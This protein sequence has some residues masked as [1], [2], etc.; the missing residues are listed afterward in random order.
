[1]QN[2]EVWL[3]NERSL[4]SLYVGTKVDES[5]DSLPSYTD[6]SKECDLLIE[7]VEWHNL[8]YEWQFT[9]WHIGFVMTRT[10]HICIL[11]YISYLGKF[12]YE[13]LFCRE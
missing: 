6:L 9:F 8:D 13:I 7:V 3:E 11:I 2:T 10:L 5:L 12:I 4:G 1:M